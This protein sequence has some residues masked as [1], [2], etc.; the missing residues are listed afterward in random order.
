MDRSDV[1]IV[2]QD[3]DWITT[4]KHCVYYL[5]HSRHI[6]D[7]EL[8]L[9]EKATDR[10]MSRLDLW[11][12]LACRTVRPVYTS[13]KLQQYVPAQ[14]SILCLLSMVPPSPHSGRY[15]GGNPC[16]IIWQMTDRYGD[17]WSLFFPSSLPPH[18]ESIRSCFTCTYTFFCTL[19]K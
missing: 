18:T 11:P 4:S 3:K 15:W 8:L 17:G 6:N 5:H 13:V 14:I 7:G 9:Q 1:D 19:Y 10:E 2:G 16:S 12:S